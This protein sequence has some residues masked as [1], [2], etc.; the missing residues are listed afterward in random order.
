MAA[1]ITLLRYSCIAFDTYP[2]N[3][4]YPGVYPRTLQGYSER[5][6]KDAVRLFVEK[7]ED[8]EVPFR[9]FGT[10]VGLERTYFE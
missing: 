3:L 9:D 4:I 5:L 7:E 6:R 2:Q 10:E 1:P 8:V